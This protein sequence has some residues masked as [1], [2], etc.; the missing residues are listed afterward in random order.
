MQWSP[1]RNGGFSRANPARLYKPL[2]LDAVYGYE[3]VNVEAQHGDPSSLLN[4]MRNMIALRKLF[5]VFGRGSLEFL[6]PE[7]RKVLAYV[8]RY[9]NDNVLCVANLSRFAQP[10]ELDL[11]ALAGMVPVEMLGYTEFPVIGRNP[12]PLTL[13][14][15]GFYWFELQGMPAPVEIETTEEA[16]EEMTARGRA[17]WRANGAQRSNRSFFRSFF[18]SSAGSEPR[19]ARLKR[20]GFAT[21]RC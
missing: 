2:I 1:D 11:S 4:W 15:Y 10:V 3:A 18:P 16:V 21:G 13:G 9:E 12:Y 20:S 14:P 19:H 6:R 7:N 8:R 17:C 5:K